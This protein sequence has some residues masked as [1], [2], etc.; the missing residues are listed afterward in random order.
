MVIFRLEYGEMEV[1]EDQEAGVS[2]DKDA[3]D[4][5]QALAPWL[6]LA[7]HVVQVVHY[8]ELRKRARAKV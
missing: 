5:A 2:V 8:P 7:E 4:A 6:L 3:A 1:K